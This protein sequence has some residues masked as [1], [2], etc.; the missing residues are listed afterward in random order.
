M[1]EVLAMSLVVRHHNTFAKSAPSHASHRYTDVHYAV[2]E[3]MAFGG[4]ERLF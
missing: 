3:I 2:Y 1:V 4:A